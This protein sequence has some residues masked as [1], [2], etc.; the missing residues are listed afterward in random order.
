MTAHR[1]LFV[2][3]PLAGHINPTLA[4]GAE[5][6]ARG[7]DVAWTGYREVLTDLLPDGWTWIP[8]ADGLP[9]PLVSTIEQRAAGLRGAAAL[10]FLWEDF[11]HPLADHMVDGVAAAIDSFDPDVVVVDQQTVAGAVVAE[12][13]GRCWATSSTT[14]AELVDPFEGL[15]KIRAWADRL[16]VDFQVAHGLPAA[17]AT[18]ERIRSS[19]HL[20]LA[21]TTPTLVGDRLHT[22]APVAFVGPAVG[23]PDPTPFP[24]ERLEVDGPKVLVSLGTVNAEAG[25]RFFRAAAE[26]LTGRCGLA[27][28]VAPPDLVG[29]VPDDVLVARRVPQLALLPYLDAVVTHG[30]HNTVCESLAHGVPLVVAPIRDDQPVI[31]EQVVA[32]GAGVRIR[33]AR[34]RPETIADALDRVL[35]D[36]EVRTAAHRVAASFAEAGGA[37]AAADRLLA[38]AAAPAVRPNRSV[39]APV[40]EP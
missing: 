17:G 9:G 24:W 7:H 6:I 27:V 25:E 11:L 19:S 2:V 8:V 39:L 4:V 33:F 32:A 1:F 34:P 16:L 23:R 14:S 3:P 35:T 37:P 20:V 15:P 29:P 12:R 38:L 21:F 22:T 26:G 10:K 13:T 18:A 5:L 30:G 31:A 40:P 28:I 36:P